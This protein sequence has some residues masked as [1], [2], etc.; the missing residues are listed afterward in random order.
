MWMENAGFLYDRLLIHKLKWA[1]LTFQWMPFRSE[2]EHQTIYHCL[3]ATHSS[4]NAQSEHLYIAEVAFPTLRDLNDDPKDLQ[5]SRV[6]PIF[7][8]THEEEINRARYFPMDS[9]LIAARADEGPICVFKYGNEFPVSLLDGNLNGG[10]ALEWSNDGLLSG[11]FS[12]KAFYWP[13]LEGTPQAVEYGS[14]VG[15]VK[16]AGNGLAAIVGDSGLLSFW[17]LRNNGI[18][19]SVQTANSDK[20]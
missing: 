3:Y 14:N 1:S 7:R 11:D 19:Q 16:M 8:F 20:R 6:K 10:F 5:A 4:G 15:D 18:V 12:G 9:S 17:D 2:Q 13:N